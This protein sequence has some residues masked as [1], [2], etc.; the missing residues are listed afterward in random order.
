MSEDKNSAPW[1]LEVDWLLRYLRTHGITPE[2]IHAVVSTPTNKPRGNY[3]SIDEYLH[4]F[5]WAAKR[6]ESPHIGLD[7]AAQLEKEDLGI[8]GYLIQNT[9]TLQSLVDVIVRYQ[10]I[11]MQGM[12]FSTVSHKHE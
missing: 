8:Y 1:G 3:L 10:S 4:L 12:E 5:A 11:F 9:S 7:I 6:L 2:E